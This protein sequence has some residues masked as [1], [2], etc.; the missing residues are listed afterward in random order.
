MLRKKQRFTTLYITLLI[1]LWCGQLY[2]QKK[3]HIQTLGVEQ[4]LSQS[5]VLTIHQDSLGFIWI[6]TRDGLNEYSG[7]AVKVYKHVLGDSLS[8]GGNQI[9]DIENSSDNNLWIAHNKGISLYKRKKGVFKNYEVGQ[10]P[11]NEIRSISI[12][13]GHIWASGWKGV[14][15]YDNE[16]DAFVKPEFELKKAYLFDASVAKIVASPNKDEYWIA[17]S[18]RGLIYYNARDKV[19]KEISSDSD[20]ITLKEKERVEDIL[21]H[22]NGRMYV[23]TY[24]NGLYECDLSGKPLRQWSASR[25][26]EY[27]SIYNNIRS[28]SIDKNGHIWIGSFQGAGI[29]NPE[30]SVITDVNILHGSAS[31][32]N[33]SVR[34]LMCDKNGSMWIGT[35]HDGLLLYDDY[36]SRF[37]IHYLPSKDS[38]GSHNIVSA[39][40]KK[41]DKL[42]VGSEIGN[43]IE[44]D[45]DFNITNQYFLRSGT[46]EN[47]VVKSLFYD[48]SND[49]LWI[50][51]LRH[52]LFM[53]RNG[54]VHS[55]GHTDL[56]V[57][58]SIVE[59]SENRLWILSDRKNGINL[60][61]I[62]TKSFEPFHAADKVHEL[63]QKSRAK[64]LLKLNA[65]A[66]LLSTIGSG[67]ILFENKPNGKVS[68]ILPEISDVNHVLI[69]SDRL[70]VSTTGSGIILLNK[71]L[72]P[73]GSY[74]T[75][76]G[77]L[78]NTVFNTMSVNGRLWI[79]SI[80]GLTYHSPEEEFVS[81]QVLNGFPL[82]EINEG[83]YLQ[84]EDRLLFG[85]KNAWVSFVPQ[86]VYKNRYKPSIFI[87]DIRINNSPIQTFPRF[88]NIDILHPGKITLKHD[89]TTLTIHF[90]G[91]NYIM[92][93]NNRYRYR[94]EGFEDSWR[95]S[96]DDGIAE[97]S[98]IPSGRY[99]LKAEASNNDGVWSEQLIVPVT[100]KP[101]L[102]LTWQAGLIYLL[103]LFGIALL[104]RRDALKKA[105]MRHSFQLKEL[106]R[107]QIEQM[108][109]LKVKYFTDISHE[110]R[111]P[112]MLILNPVEEMIDESS[113][114]PKDRK[115]MSRILYHGKSLLQLVN[116]LLEI[117]RIELK[118]EKLNETP[119]FLRFFFDNVNQSFSSIADS[120]KIDWHVDTSNVT[121]KALLIDRDKLEKVV[122]NLLSNAFKYTSTGGSIAL[123]ASTD[124]DGRSKKYTL[125]IEVSDTGIGMD[126]EDLPHIFDRFY[127]ADNQKIQ[128][129]GIGLSLVKTIVKDLMNGTIT[130]ESEKGV[131]SRF[132]ITIPDR[133]VDETATSE[134]SLQ[135]FTLS[136]DVSLLLGSYKEKEPVFVQEGKRKK[137]NIL[138]VEDNISLLNSLSEN[139][140]KLFTVFAVTSAEEGKDILQEEDIDLV[141][142]DIMLPGISGKDFCADIKSDIVTSHIPVVLLTAIQQEEVKIE[143][144]G[145]GADDYIVKPFSQKELRLRVMNIL[146]R[147]EQLRK[148]Y[149][150]QTLPEKEETRF[151]QFD[152]DLIKRINELID[153]N[154]DNTQYSIEDLSADVGLSRVHLYRKLKK[155]L[156]VSP[157]RYMRDYRL[158][159]AAKIL[160][161]EDLRIVEVADRVGFQD[162]N[163]FVKCFKEKFGISPKK[164]ADRK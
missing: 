82:P 49:I 92:S 98:K 41:K 155:L 127:K 65:D 34:S 10:V 91:T 111:T 14:Y 113:L 136:S 103:L 141:I 121:E 76:D 61:N 86:N 85:G 69:Q 29:L 35:Y 145:L 120:N 12:I 114:V 54:Q 116:Q 135:E 31:I 55:L 5:S 87:S 147:Q 143:S 156:G 157:S 53:L 77:L 56:S 160:S 126:K 104:I 105:E 90:A 39:F 72:E 1:F 70:Y 26:G 68:R 46:N 139:L 8:L 18:T 124:Y 109:N 52:G 162:A 50:G 62:A 47:V 21:F 129:T 96:S 17:S 4:G 79:N 32:D 140:S 112:L 159:K 142:S 63:V 122:L 161:K 118:K 125:L 7:N 40:A 75:Q 106:E 102:W 110:I 58:N 131:G 30:T 28:L 83:A 148:L 74:T 57:I 19:V 3:I 71:N 146:N 51:T 115:K 66:Y 15:I 27:R 60:F 9:N 123:K 119:V 151:N 24:H 59:E 73:I 164:Y 108:H 100:V 154:L 158:S 97:Y 99:L 2:S 44:Y 88:R 22:P 134:A 33:A 6:G 94:L 150:K 138:L 163:Y 107:E 80:N 132:V 16:K 25:T 95:Y 36:F 128:G 11:N 64:H 152:N 89:E 81:Y 130:V 78:N 45:K 149:K 48:S 23:A 67:L 153:Q 117:N 13:N 137:Q 101:P 93:E 43:L 84:T 144:L 20:G 133:V 42:I 38:F 37:N